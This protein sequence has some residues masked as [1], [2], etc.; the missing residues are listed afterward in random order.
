MGQMLVPSVISQNAFRQLRS[1]SFSQLALRSGQL[2]LDAPQRSWLRAG[3][4]KSR[5]VLSW[6]PHVGLPVTADP[7]RSIGYQV[8]G[9]ECLPQTIVVVNY[10]SSNSPSSWNLLFPCSS[11]CKCQED[12]D[13]WRRY[14]VKQK[15]LAS[16][17]GWVELSTLNMTWC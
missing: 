9:E 14:L 5:I 8:K 10:T 4:F 13:N 7:E 6:S 12:T 17:W 3:P 15:K 16:R 1:S 11:H 2:A